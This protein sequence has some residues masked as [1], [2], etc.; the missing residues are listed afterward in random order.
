MTQATFGRKETSVDWYALSI[1]TWCFPFYLA[2]KVSDYLS[3][4]DETHVQGQWGTQ[5]PKLSLA[6]SSTA[7]EFL[8]SSHLFGRWTKLQESPGPD[9]AEGSLTLTTADVIQ[10]SACLD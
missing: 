1:P 8:G 5:S 4:K 9:E 3:M 2:S 6:V 10:V 7:H